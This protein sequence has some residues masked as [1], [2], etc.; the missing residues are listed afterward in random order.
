MFNLKLRNEKLRK[1]VH[2]K[3]QIWKMEKL[4][5]VWN[6]EQTKNSKISNFWAKFW[7]PKLKIV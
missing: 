6:I 4:R 2:I 1:F 7:F 3:R 5:V